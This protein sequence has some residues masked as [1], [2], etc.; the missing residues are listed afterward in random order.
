MPDVIRSRAVAFL[1]AV[2][3]VLGALTVLAAPAVVPPGAAEL[4]ATIAAL[5]DPGLEGRRSG[6]PGG[7]GAAQRLAA[8]LQAAGLEP[9]GDHGTFLQSFVLER[10][11]RP[12]PTS[13]LELE[14]GPARRLVFGRDFAPHA[15]SRAGEAAG[16][17]V[18]VGYGVSA[19]D[20]G[21]DDWAG[22]DVRGRL[23]LVLDGAPP[24]L[25]DGRASRIEKLLAART[26]GAAALLVVRDA[27]PPADATAAA[28][29][30]LSATLTRAGADALLA[31]AGRTIDELAAPLA[32]TGAPASVATGARARL[33]VD[34]VHDAR[35]AA[36]VV[37]VLRGKDPLRAGDALVIGAHYDHLGR[38]E[39]IVHPGADDNASGTALVVGLARAFAAAGGVDRTL[40]FVLFGAEE[41]GLLG[42][43]HYV[44]EPVV[45]LAQTIAMLNFDMVGR[46]R[47]RRLFVGGGDSAGGLRA[48]AI[49]ASRGTD[50]TPEVS[51]TP[52]TPSDH[53]R[54]YDAGVPVLFFSTGGHDDHHR[55]SDTVD[56]IDADGIARVAAVAARV[57]ERLALVP[58]PT[59]ARLARPAA[60]GGAGGTAADGA[61]LG[62]VAASRPAP[63][64]LWLSGVV[65]GS[66]AATAGLREGDVIVRFGRNAVDGLDALR[67]LLRHRRPGDS[68]DV[69]YLRDGEAHA[70]AATLGT[71]P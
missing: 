35:R 32:T 27:L 65:P 64:G 21:W 10:A 2:C 33:R 68:V 13:A 7:E 17:V 57:V 22:V 29:N 63:D 47:H 23:A 24:Q 20:A 48:L 4:G 42:S 14:G 54:F 67:G 60:R 37:G 56:K 18:F 34:I 38:I 8:W 51:G 28:V 41:L 69:V 70:T 45:P 12:A 62:I 39:G 40:V 46:L 16:D 61:F 36:N 19:P 66:G 1:L 43:G 9:G 55:P 53:S 3:C 58:R 52:W 50:V 15:G 44:R 49:E 6:T 30:V 71:H 26:H 25:T 11:A 59:Y 5:T 31:P